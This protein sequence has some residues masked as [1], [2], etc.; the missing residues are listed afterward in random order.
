[1]KFYN[2]WGW[3]HAKWIKGEDGFTGVNHVEDLH[4]VAI[5]D[6]NPKCTAKAKEDFS[7]VDTYVR[8][9]LEYIKKHSI[10]YQRMFENRL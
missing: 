10:F 3:M 1:M 7:K 6:K 4:L 9:L 2:T 5:C 8:I